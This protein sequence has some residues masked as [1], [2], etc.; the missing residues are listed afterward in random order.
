MSLQVDLPS[1]KNRRSRSVAGAVLLVLTLWTGMLYAPIVNF[2][3]IDIYDDWD[4]VTE[5]T[6]VL[7]GLSPESIGWAFSETHSANWH[8][9]T[10]MSHMADV[11]LFGRW[12]GGHH[13]SSLLFHLINAALLLVALYMMTGALWRSAVVAAVF[14][15]HPI[16]VE[17]VAWV[18]E[19]K[20][21]LSTMFWMLSL[22]A[23]CRYAATEKRGMLALVGVCMALGLMA[24]PMV[25]TLP[26]ALILLDIWPL[27][28][29]QVASFRRWRRLF[30]EKWF[31]FA[32]SG[33]S[34]VITI[35]SQKSGG[36]VQTLHR[37]PLDSRIANALCAYIRYVGKL[38]FPENLAIPYPYPEKIPL[39]AVGGAAILLIAATTV[40]VRQIYRRPWCF[41]GWFWFVGTL[42]PVIG[43]VQVGEQSM[44]DRYAYIP[45]IGLFMTIVWSIPDNAGE[46]RKG[47]GCLAALA[48]L[49]MGFLSWQTHKQLQ[50][51]E[52]NLS[53]FAHTTAVTP[54]N[55]T[56]LLNLGFALKTAG[57]MDEA[58]EQYRRILAFDPFNAKANSNVGG[59]LMARG[60]IDTA[61]AYIRKAIA[62][63][64][65]NPGAHNNLGSALGRKGDIAGALEA[66]RTALAIDADYAEAHVNLAGLLMDQG[67]DALA[68]PHL[69]R[70]LSA[71]PENRVASALL[72]LSLIRSGRVGEGEPLVR[73]AAAGAPNNPH[74][75]KAVGE[76]ALR[77][78][79]ID[80]AE[81]AY[82]QLLTVDAENIDALLQLAGIYGQ[83]PGREKAAIGLMKRAAVL[84]PDRSVLDYNIACMYGRLGDA[85]SA[86]TWLE[87]ARKKGYGPLGQA[88]TDPDLDPIRQSP[89]FER[90]YRQH[91]P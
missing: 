49:V 22:I 53:L 70:V 39:W 33:A 60:E 57:R 5:N 20:N 12:A 25:V 65:G 2:D 44:A 10:W 16:N 58:L 7:K 61:I 68:V 79:R 18:A 56:A 38:V 63:D 30:A 88:A 89:V 9:I 11:E 91:L 85:E 45:M 82:R 75:L 74:V 78:G 17:S 80:A 84:L 4:Y 6:A 83:R 32:L 41:V 81:Q 15:L 23:Y 36:A 77:A 34:V 66:Y 24:K 48:V 71:E 76:A 51:W 47:R 29:C 26:F 59:V 73:A 21:V 86:V 55:R 19:R 13:L 27:S 69:R 1:V 8:P 43:I 14:A 90:W 28:R 50:Y 35:I 72:G 3:F 40:A 42:V 62:L 37:Y 87:T 67:Q 64:P 52:S 46:S 31:L 54:Q